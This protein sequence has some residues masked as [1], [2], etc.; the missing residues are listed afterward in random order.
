MNTD[1]EAGRA[2]DRDIFC[3]FGYWV[4]PNGEIESISDW[5]SHQDDAP[6]IVEKYGID[7]HLDSGDFL[8]PGRALE[9][10]GWVSVTVNEIFR[11]PSFS[12]A[13]PTA[14]QAKALAKCLRASAKA[15]GE[16]YSHI[17]SQQFHLTGQ[18]IAYINKQRDLGV[19]FKEN[20]PKLVTPKRGLTS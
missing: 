8:E 20:P 12:I 19:R 16:T 4:G 14:A 3:Y 15:Y 7:L 11:A 5:Q 1:I 9:E 18:A 2:A 10:L 17:N 6:N 13:Y